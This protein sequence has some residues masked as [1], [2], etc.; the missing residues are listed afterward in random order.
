[1]KDHMLWTQSHE[2]PNRGLKEPTSRENP[3]EGEPPLSEELRDMS[4]GLIR[5]RQLAN[6]DKSI[7]FTQLF[8]HI[9]YF[10]LV[11][12]FKELKKGAAP[13]I[14]GL[15]WTE[16]QEDLRHN[17][18]TLNEKLQS[19]RYRALPARRVYIPKGP[20]SK[21]P[22]GIVALEDKIVQRAVAS[23]LG[24]I[25]EEDFYGFSYGFRPRRGCHDALD[26]LAVAIGRKKVNWVLDAD[27]KGFFDSISHEHLMSFLGGRIGDPRILRLIRKWLK[28]GVIEEGQWLFTEEGTPQGGVISP[29][30]ANVFYITC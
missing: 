12:C 1:M 27:I 29:L 25:Y 28:A 24:E 4:T 3:P 6:K 18:L 10:K 16:Y 19:G 26:A 7:R 21:R 2:I 17:I 14:D 23:I 9:T 22:L 8:Q 5:M 20:D 13:G 15:S 30:L 11:S